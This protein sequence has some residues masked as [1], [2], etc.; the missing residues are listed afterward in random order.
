VSKPRFAEA[1]YLA[2]SATLPLHE[3]LSALEDTFALPPFA[4]DGKASWEYAYSERGDL[5]LNVT[6]AR[7]TDV[8]ETW[9]EGTPPGS[10][11]QIIVYTEPGGPQHQDVSDV[12]RERCGMITKYVTTS[13]HPFRPTYP[14]KAGESPVPFDEESEPP[15]G[16][17]LPLS[18][19]FVLGFVAAA[20]VA[21][22]ACM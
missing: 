14:A 12:L 19:F 20:V 1:H 16:W 3:V 7:R 8:I 18:W 9:V 2:S 21:A 4:L 17:S 11:Y 10:T 13:I 22:R 6:R 15:S 5:G